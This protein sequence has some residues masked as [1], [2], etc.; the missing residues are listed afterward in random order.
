VDTLQRIPF[1]SAFLDAIRHFDYGELEYQK[2]I[3]DWLIQDSTAA[4]ERGTRIW[5]YR[6]EVGD[7]IGYGSLG[8]TSW[9]YPG[10]KSPKSPIAV[11]P[12]LGIRKEFR[13]Q[14]ATDG[15]DE[16]YSSQILGLGSV[17]YPGYLRLLPG[18]SLGI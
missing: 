13:G 16:R 9:S 14:P 5:L 10:K 17:K 2:E 18:R 15:K 11:I 4:M 3:A 6:N 1:Q 7:F 8:T 12:A